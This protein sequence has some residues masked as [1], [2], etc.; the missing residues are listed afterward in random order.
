MARIA[1]SDRDGPADIGD[2]GSPGSDPPHPLRAAGAIEPER[3]VAPALALCLG[4]GFASLAGAAPPG[5][6]MTFEATAYALDGKTAAGS[7]TEAG[8][9]AADP[10]VL[11]LGTRIRIHGAGPYSGDYVVKDTGRTI[12]GREIDI[13]VESARQARKFGRRKVKVEV[14]ARGQ[15]R[16]QAKDAPLPEASIAPALR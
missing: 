8:I 7:R 2:L 6:A 10:D 15:G 13:F 16:E 5:G 1:M 12:D 9:V 4:L 11:P 14:L 3:R